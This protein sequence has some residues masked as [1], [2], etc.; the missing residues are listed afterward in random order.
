M[1]K[2]ENQT[3]CVEDLITHFKKQKKLDRIYNF[4]IIGGAAVIILSLFN[5]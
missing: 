5:F 2:Y 4:I 1:N 3:Q